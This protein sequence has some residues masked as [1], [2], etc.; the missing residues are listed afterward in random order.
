M[1]N[2]QTT[3]KTIARREFARPDGMAGD[4]GLTYGINRNGLHVILEALPAGEDIAGGNVHRFST[5]QEARACWI[6]LQS[7]WMSSGYVI[8][9]TGDVLKAKLA[10]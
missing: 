5:K 8:G 10:A 9:N 3:T 7:A 6:K 4:R 1:K 2:T